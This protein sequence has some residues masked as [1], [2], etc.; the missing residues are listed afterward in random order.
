M[1]FPSYTS[2]TPK[3][4]IQNY[5]VQINHC[6]EGK[7]I[8]IALWNILMEL[9]SGILFKD[10]LVKHMEEYVDS[11]SYSDAKFTNNY[12]LPANDFG[13][14]YYARPYSSDFL[15]NICS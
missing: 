11:A 13:E 15:L 4:I 2:I 12:N 5:A 6:I 7:K 1:I 8:V 10:P 14:P 3:S 9:F